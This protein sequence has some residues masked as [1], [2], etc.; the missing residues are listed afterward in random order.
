[1]LATFGCGSSKTHIASGQALRR[2]APRVPA[3][4]VRVIIN[5]ATKSLAA[6]QQ[7]S[8]KAIAQYSQHHVIR[9]RRV[10][11]YLLTRS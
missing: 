5:G 7:Y 4:D 3:A 1:M 11:G 6:C 10:A 8:A 9:R 2:V